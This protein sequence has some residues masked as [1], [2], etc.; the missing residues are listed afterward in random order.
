MSGF[1]GTS[2]ML[3]SGVSEIK[4]LNI[5][6]VLDSTYLFQKEREIQTLLTTFYNTKKTFYF[7]IYCERIIINDN[8][9]VYTSC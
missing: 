6:L 2:V 8:I 9:N 3:V 4:P 7:Y 1:V 5:S